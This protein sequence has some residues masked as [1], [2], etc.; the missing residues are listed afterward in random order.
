MKK[1]IFIIAALV[2]AGVLFYG[3][4]SN[5]PVVEDGYLPIIED[6]LGKEARDENL[7]LD[8]DFDESLDL[9]GESEI[10][11]DPGFEG[12]PLPGQNLEDGSDADGEQTAGI[13][14]EIK[15]TGTLEEVNTAC[16]ADGECYVRVDGKKVTLLLGWSRDTVGSVRDTDGIGGLEAHIGES[17]EVYAA[18]TLGGTYTLYGKEDYYVSPITSIDVQA[19]E[20]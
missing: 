6:V 12:I 1:T 8:K 9:E 7:I 16:F 10:Y 14:S 13:E 18:S 11:I 5:A 20:A 15:F 2:I 3:V 4:R 19:N 17:V